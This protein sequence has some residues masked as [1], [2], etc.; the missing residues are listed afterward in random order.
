MLIKSGGVSVQRRRSKLSRKGSFLSSV[1]QP[2][3]RRSSFVRGDV[4]GGTSARAGRSRPSLAAIPAHTELD[5]EAVKKMEEEY[6]QS[7]HICD[8]L[9][10]I[11]IVSLVLCYCVRD[12]TSV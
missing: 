2:L 1:Q 6:V 11:C 4:S 3:R 12:N 8:T 9:T 5:L 7:T 10:H